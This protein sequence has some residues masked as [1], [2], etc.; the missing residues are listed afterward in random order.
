MNVVLDSECILHWILIKCCAEYY[1]ILCWILMH[2]VLD[3][4]TV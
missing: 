4:D 3:I 2:T 1:C